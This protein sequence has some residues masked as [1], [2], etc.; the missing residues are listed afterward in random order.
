[1]HG[2]IGVVANIMEVELKHIFSNFCSDESGATAIEYGLIAAG[3][4]L[5]IIAAVNGLGS[6]L[7]D[8]F[9]SINSSLK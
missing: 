1:M 4:A 3:I 2:A 6:T 7:S 8:R 9:T 5:A